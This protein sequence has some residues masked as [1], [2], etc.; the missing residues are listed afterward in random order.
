MIAPGVVAR[1]PAGVANSAARNHLLLDRTLPVCYNWLHQSPLGEETNGPLCFACQ[2]RTAEN[3]ARRRI[4]VERQ[5]HRPV[6]VA[7]EHGHAAPV[8]V[9]TGGDLR[10]CGDCGTLVVDLS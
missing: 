4:C 6:G 7:V 10:E 9:S 3:V 2:P 8:S 5:S 1:A